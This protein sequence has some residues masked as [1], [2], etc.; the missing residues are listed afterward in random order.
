MTAAIRDFIDAQG[1]ADMLGLPNRAAFLSRRE[2]L[3]ALE[4]FPL[5]MPHMRRP[6]LWRRSQVAAWIEAQGRYAPDVTAADVGPN[7]VLL[8]EARRA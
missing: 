3:E 2:A 5:P 8:R 4:E 1:V 7:V 6:L